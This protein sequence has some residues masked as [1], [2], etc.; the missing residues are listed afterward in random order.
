MERLN[1]N[2]IIC[3]IVGINYLEKV[4]LKDLCEKSKKFNLID[5]DILNEDILKSEE[6]NKM[7]KSYSKMKKNKNDKYKD[8]D[9]KMTTYWEENLVKKVYDLIPS[10]KKCIFR[11]TI[12]NWL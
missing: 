11:P 4:K 1:E 8:V 5:L 12:T 6:M 9:K 2:K 7:F 3:H 10:K